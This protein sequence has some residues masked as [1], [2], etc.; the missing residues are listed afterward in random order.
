MDNENLVLK[1]KHDNWGEIGPNAWQGTEWKIYGDLKMEVFLAVNFG[2]RKK[3]QTKI[4]QKDF[5]HILSLIRQSEKDDKKVEALDGSVWEIKRY[6]GKTLTW[7]R[8]IGYIYGIKSLETLA[9]VLYKLA[10]L[11][12][13]KW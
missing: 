7:E 13:I 1:I 10:G 6:Q 2:D 3:K 5:D 12:Q 9:G 8:K 4:S 11:K